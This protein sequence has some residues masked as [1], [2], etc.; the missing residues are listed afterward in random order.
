MALNDECILISSPDRSKPLSNTSHTSKSFETLLKN[1]KDDYKIVN[2]PS[3]RLTATCWK[4][5]GFPARVID[6]DEFEIIPGFASCKQCFETFR[7]VG[8]I[9][10]KLET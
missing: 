6:G 8:S 3:K 7:H 9:H 10:V 1:N 2:N 5:F 4:L